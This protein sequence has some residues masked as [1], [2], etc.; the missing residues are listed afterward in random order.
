M[1]IK[2]SQGQN[3]EGFFEKCKAWKVCKKASWFIKMM[4]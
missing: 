2:L 3:Q 4:G 1:D